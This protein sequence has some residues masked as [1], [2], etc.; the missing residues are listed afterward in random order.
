MTRGDGQYVPS[1]CL[2]VERTL[3]FTFRTRLWDTAISIEALTSRDR[4]YRCITTRAAPARPRAVG[5]TQDGEVNRAVT[6]LRRNRC[7]GA[8]Q[9]VCTHL[10]SWR[11]C[12]RRGRWGAAASAPS[13][14]FPRV[15][16]VRTST[17]LLYLFPVR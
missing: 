11:R 6:R 15:N 17:M 16:T 7:P 1:S 3:T 14:T 5:T 8:L 2:Q 10:P 4:T 13:C 12:P 9:L